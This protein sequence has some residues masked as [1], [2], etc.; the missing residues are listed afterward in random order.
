MSA[1]LQMDFQMSKGS[2]EDFQAVVNVLQE[3]SGEEINK[4][5]PEDVDEETEWETDLDMDICDGSF[6]L[7]NGFPN[8]WGEDF[9]ETD[10]VPY[11]RFAKAAPKAEWTAS[12]HRHYDVDGTESEDT[13]SYSEGI[14]KYQYYDC[15]KSRMDYDG[16]RDWVKYLHSIRYGEDLVLEGELTLEQL[17]AYFKEIDLGVEALF[18][19]K[20]GLKKAE[21]CVIC[22][23]EM[24]TL[25]DPDEFTY[26]IKEYFLNGKDPESLEGKTIAVTGKLAYFNNRDQL[27]DY[28]ED[29][30]GKVTDSVSK[31]NDFL[32]CNNANATSTKAKKAAELGV[33]VLTEAEFIGRFGFPDDGDLEEAFDDEDD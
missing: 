14:L 25:Y 33:P 17:S 20:V 7:Y 29:N 13:A 18:N 26:V 8:I 28:V 12:S 30:G 32:L 16:L 11:I 5:E 31:K 2:D 1:Y 21:F 6:T 24:L 3:I 19:K 10:P 9:L 27:T 15:F 4:T 22:D 23:G